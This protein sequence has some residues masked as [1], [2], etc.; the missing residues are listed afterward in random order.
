MLKAFFSSISPSPKNPG[1]VIFLFLSTILEKKMGVYKNLF[2]TSL[3][4]GTCGS[5]YLHL[6]LRNKFPDIPTYELPKNSRTSSKF[7]DVPEG[8]Y[9]A[10]CDT[11]KI[12][13]DSNKINDLPKIREIFLDQGLL[14]HLKSETG[15][16]KTEIYDPINE[17]VRDSTLL[18]W[19]WT[20]TKLV[21]FFEKI[22]NYGYPWRLMSGGFHELYIERNGLDKIDVYYSSA[23]QYKELRDGKLIPKLV[24]C[25]HRDFARVLLQSSLSQYE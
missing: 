16:L 8:T 5:Y 15:P 7:K 11:F 19:K 10:Y 18:K 12:T 14:K 1:K 20:D 4:G 2:Y 17:K 6:Q 13:L 9:T 25:L 21:D 3:I 24:Q 23:H 22:S